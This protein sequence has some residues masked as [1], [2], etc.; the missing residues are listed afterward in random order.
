MAT[1]A[2]RDRSRAVDPRAGGAAGV[3]RDA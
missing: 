2:D 1:P 3:T